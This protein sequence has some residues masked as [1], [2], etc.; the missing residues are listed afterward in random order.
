MKKL[1]T[2]SLVIILTNSAFAQAPDKMSYQCVVRNASGVLVTNQAVGIRISILQGTS[3]GTVIYQEI[4][5]PNP[6]TNANGLVTVEIGSG[7]PL[8][9]IFSNINWASGP[10]FLKTETDPTGGTSYTITG[11]SQILSV[12]YA[13]NAKTAATA[14]YNDLSNLPSLNIPNWNTAYVWGNHATAGYLKSF[15]EAD[16]IFGTSPSKGI[17]STNITNWNTAYGWGNHTGLYKLVS[18][19]PAWSEITSNPFSISTPANNQLLKYNSTSSKWENWTP[20]F[21]TSYTETDPIWITA[22]A[23]YY[24]K[25]NL[26]TSGQALLNATNITTGTLVVARGGTGATTLTGILIGNGTGAITAVTHSGGSQYLRRNAGNTS[27][28]FGAL[29]SVATSGDYNSLLNRPTILNI[30]LSSTATG[31][32][33]LVNNIGTNNTANGEQALY[34]NTTGNNNTADGVGALGHNTTGYNNTAIGSSVLPYNTTGNNNTAVGD[35]ALSSNVGNSRSTAIGYQAMYNA[36]NGTTVKETFNTAVGYRALRGSITPSQNTGQGNTAV[37]D[38]ALF[39]IS[40]G[41]QNTAVGY[42]TLFSST[43]SGQNTAIGSDALYLNTT[44]YANVALGFEALYNNTSACCNVAIGYK[45]LHDNTTGLCNTTIGESALHSNTTGSNNTA[46]GSSTL[47]YNSSGD[48]NTAIGEDALFNNSTGYGNTAL[49]QNAGSSITTGSDLTVI[50]YGAQ[51]SSPTATKQITLGDWN[52]TSLRCNVTS[53]TSLSDARDKKNISDLTLG[54]DFIM[55]IKPRQFNW[56]RREWYTNNQSDGSK[57]QKTPAAG[58]IAQELDETQHSAKAEWLNLV[59][60]D[61]P[62]KW[63]ATTGNLLPIMVKAIQEQQKQ[64]DEL[65]KEIAVLKSR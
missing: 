17:T 24:T 18:Y 21:L 43:I 16:P 40:A 1:F 45:S 42:R 11:T 55:K 13:L 64:I 14:N 37:G 4:Y 9:G 39:S 29:S 12:P 30:S 46:I 5:N 31:H 35:G 54:L 50:G 63:E 15:T 41:S 2:L 49:G 61:N 34:L 53:I 32:L 28:E 60:K 20:N 51:P 62:E 59:L 38:Q 10:Y 19:V 25:T 56:D 8:T 26:Q 58:F 48:Y 23:N 6:Q 22:S 47:F 44:G 27:F 7:T 57:I 52:I 36:H 3:T 33:A 65:R